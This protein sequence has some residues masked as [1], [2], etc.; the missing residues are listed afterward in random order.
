M[1]QPEGVKDTI[2]PKQFGSNTD[3]T[4]ATVAGRGGWV[5]CREVT[6]RRQVGLS[7]CAAGSG[8]SSLN[9]GQLHRLLSCLAFCILL[10]A[11]SETGTPTDP[12]NP[13]PPPAAN[14]GNLQLTVEGLP[15][16]AEADVS[17][18]GPEDYSTAVTGSQTLQSLRTGS[19]TV[20]AETVSYQ[21]V[22]YT[23]LIAE[24]DLAEVTVD[25]TEG[26]TV[27]VTVTYTSIGEVGPGELAP[28]ITRTGTV[29][30]NAFDD[31]S[32]VGVEN[33]PLTFDFTGTG[34]E[35][36]GRY[37]V[38]VYR[39]GELE[40]PLFSSNLLNASLSSPLLGFAPPKNGS[41]VFRIRGEG[42]VVDYDV[43]AGYLNGS[44]E[45]RS[46]PTLLQ[47]GDEVQGA[48]TIDSYDE[49]RF[50]GTFNEPVLL[51]FSYDLTDTRYRG[52]LYVEVYRAGQSEPLLTSRVFVTYGAP[53][54]IDFTPPEDGDYLVRVLGSELGA[55]SSGASL[56]RYSFVFE[57]LE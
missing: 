19:Y 39:A 29:A 56:V 31:Y 37:S 53:P 5:G 52:G 51:S 10:I 46:D 34:E 16:G 26:E 33:V 8:S 4:R 43:T 54:E 35:R 17:V 7:E 3:A 6:S 48:V 55:S 41:Y 57:R 15:S 25:V 22:S 49:Y 40:E 42:D 36:N 27:A 11:C 20:S 21:G 2:R 28:G 24:P 38:S 50:S 23:A 12:T 45:E 32:F 30:E 14:T 13:T 47:E 44:P 18:T 1:A 9:P